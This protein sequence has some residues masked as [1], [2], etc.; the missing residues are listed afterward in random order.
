MSDREFIYLCKQLIDQR[1]LLGDVNG[2]WKQRDF[3]QLSRIIE[4]KSGIRISLSTLKRLWKSDFQQTPH[5]AT[6]DALASLLDC[7]DWLEFKNQHQN[8]PIHNPAKV[9]GSA[10]WLIGALLLITLIIVGFLVIKPEINENTTHQATI[11]M[12]HGPVSFTTNK[13]VATG[14]PNTVIFKYD[15]KNIVA[16]SFYLQQSWNDQHRVPI[17]PDA[18]NYSSIYYTPGFHRA[19]LLANDSIFKVSRIH[20]KTDGWLPLV[21]YT[22]D[23]LVPVYLRDPG[24]HKDGSLHV[25]QDQLAIAGVDTSKEFLLNYHNVQDFGLDSDNFQLS[26]RIKCD[27]IGNYPCPQFSLT[28][29]CEE[30]IFYIPMTTKGCVANIGVKVGEVIKDSQNSDLSAFGRDMY[31]WQDLH[32]TIRQKNAEV[33]I[34]SEQV[35]TGAFKQNFGK[36]MGVVLT[37]TGTGSVEYVE[38][39]DLKDNQVLADSFF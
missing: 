17:D 37:F 14:V 11:P 5:P 7:Q 30:H 35:Y 6:L 36:I 15:V 32:V 20:I 3:E 16:D 12:A 23:D 29:V 34:G 2:Q 31:Q 27:S 8:H 18:G 38:L 39:R 26:T 33:R 4:E 10:A 1:Y 22:R 28:L 25:T 13:T 19:K 9:S 24:I 21:K